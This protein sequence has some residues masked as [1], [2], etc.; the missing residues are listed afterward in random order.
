MA[1]VGGTTSISLRHSHNHNTQPH[2]AT[3]NMYTEDETPA[4]RANTQAPAMLLGMEEGA[5]PAQAH[6][7][8]GAEKGVPEKSSALAAADGCTAERWPSA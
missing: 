6:A 8:S 1:T 4:Q 5:Q 7:G 2:Q 3:T